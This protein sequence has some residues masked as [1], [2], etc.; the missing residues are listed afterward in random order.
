MTK[1][2]IYFFV[3]FVIIFF[4]DQ[5]IKQIFLD[6]YRYDGEVISL[7]FVLNNGVA[8]SM[9]AFLGEYLK[10]IQIVLLL[11][12]C[13]YLV[14]NKSLFF[15]LSAPFGMLLGAGFSNVYDRFIHGGV[16]DYI[17]WHYWFDFAVF[18]FAD[19]AID[20]SVAVIAY[21]SLVKTNHKDG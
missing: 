8:F 15:R 19:V 6:G 9:F 4:I 11:L 5:E 17:Y 2:I 18:N 13:I 12:V 16:V 10:Y 7:T 3:S 1:N 21:V 20:F 14:F